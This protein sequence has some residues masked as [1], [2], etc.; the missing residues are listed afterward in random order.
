MFAKIVLGSINNSMLKTQCVLYICILA[1]GNTLIFLSILKRVCQ[2]QNIG[3]NSCQ[4]NRVVGVWKVFH[5]CMYSYMRIYACICALFIQKTIHIMYLSLQ[6]HIK[7]QFKTY[8]FSEHNCNLP[9]IFVNRT[10][11]CSIVQKLRTCMIFG[12]NFNGKFCK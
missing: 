11:G 5:S 8:W 9:L 4:K 7:T 3:S 2:V 10:F 12:T 6:M 1:A